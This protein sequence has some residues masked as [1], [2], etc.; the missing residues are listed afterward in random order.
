MIE[1]PTEEQLRTLT[2]IVYLIKNK[3]TGMCYIG[4]TIR[5]FSDRYWSCDWQKYTTNNYL[6]NSVNKHGINNFMLYILDMGINNDQQL[7]DT[8]SKFIKQ[9]NTLFPNGYNF[10]EE[11]YEAKIFTEEMKLNIALAGCYGKIYRIKEIK[12]GEIK[13][14]RCPKEI[15]DKYGV[16][17]QNLHALFSGKL[18]T[19]KGICLPD[20]NT[21]KWQENDRLKILIDQHGKKYEF[22]NCH[23]FARENE[24][25]SNAILYTVLNEVS[26]AKSK[27]GRIFR[28]ETTSEQSLEY[29]KSIRKISPTQ[30][31]KLIILTRIIDNVDFNINP[32]DIK[33]FCLEHKI[34]QTLP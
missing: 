20:T 23:K 19:L 8:E 30:K 1:N 16:K 31:Y 29:L 25:A 10:L 5:K 32:N 24:C 17:D 22:Y 2:G 15:I 12:T 9:Y 21:D 18:R 28:L 33:S 11:N 3:I 6:K 4:K 7:L 14:F 13:E 26:A 34:T 27:D